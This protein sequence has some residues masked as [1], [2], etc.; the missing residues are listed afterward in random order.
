MAL[1][2]AKLGG[3]ATNTPSDGQA[4]QAHRSRSML[5]VSK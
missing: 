1:G 2:N 3:G 5:K 4:G